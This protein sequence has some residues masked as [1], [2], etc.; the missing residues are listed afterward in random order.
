MPISQELP[1]RLRFRFQR[2]LFYSFLDTIH[3]II[4]LNSCYC[5][6]IVDFR[7]KKVPLNCDIKHLEKCVC[8]SSVRP[9]NSDWSFTKDLYLA[10]VPNLIFLLF[11]KSGRFHAWN[12]LN[13][14]IQ[15]KLFTFIEF[16]RKLCHMKSEIQWILP[17]IRQTSW[18]PPVFHEIYWDFTKTNRFLQDFIKST[19]FNTIS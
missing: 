6:L 10:I 13:Q 9:A 2:E 15:E 16:R 1:R 12:P 11:M 8:V 4:H 18:N 5:F 7:W 17:E 14:I 3:V 19:A